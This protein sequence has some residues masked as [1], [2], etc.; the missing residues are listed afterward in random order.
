MDNVVVD[1]AVHVYVCGIALRRVFEGTS[2][3]GVLK[4][5]EAGLDAVELGVGR[6][7][8]FLELYGHPTASR[9]EVCRF[10]EILLQFEVAIAGGQVYVYLVLCDFLFL[11]DIVHS[12]V[13]SVDPQLD[14]AVARRPV[15]FQYARNLHAESI[16]QQGLVGVV[17]EEDP[18]A[19]RRH[20]QELLLG[21][22][23]YLERF[24]RH[25]PG[26]VSAALYGGLAFQSGHIAVM[27][28]RVFDDYVPVNRVALV[29]AVRT[30][31]QEDLGHSE[32]LGFEFGLFPGFE[33]QQ[34]SVACEDMQG[35]L[36]QIYEY[37]EA[38]L[39]ALALRSGYMRLLPLHQPAFFGQYDRRPVG[40]AAVVYDEI[41]VAH[42]YVPVCENHVTRKGQGFESV[43]KGSVPVCL[44]QIQVG[45]RAREQTL[46]FH[47][48]GGKGKQ[49][50]R[51][52]NNMAQFHHFWNTLT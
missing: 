29:Y 14:Y 11:E 6:N 30:V 21:F 44:H 25:I 7:L 3:E 13:F 27:A 48:A 36:V 50:Y 35:F 41:L 28:V 45:L 34:F 5:V 43:E 46:F 42:I 9:I 8:R 1:E 4:V 17:R 26:R 15:H 51:K 22:K 47:P 37:G 39:C 32:D 49:R 40:G 10:V 20:S 23:L 33:A 52:E 16:A 19:V 2:P 38:L 31:G 12:L 18:V 24:L